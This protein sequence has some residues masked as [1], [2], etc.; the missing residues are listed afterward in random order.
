MD[1]Q[2]SIHFDRYAESHKHCA[3]PGDARPTALQIIRDED[4]EGRLA[5]KVILITGGSSGIGVET[6]R[7]LAHTGA[8]I[9]VGV[10]NLPKGQ[11]VLDDI[12]EKDSVIKKT[13][14][15][16]LEMD[17]N[18]LDSVRQAADIFLTKHKQ[19]N[20]LVNNAGKH[21]YIS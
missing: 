11:K 13:Q 8:K 20:I 9:I 5:D 15:E 14:L 12:L 18:S 2:Q 6:A 17:L 19:L 1:H 21:Y 3:G 16:L 10:R 4:L 7:A